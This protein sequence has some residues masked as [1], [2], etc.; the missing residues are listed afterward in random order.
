MTFMGVS[1]HFAGRIIA[2]KRRAEALSRDIAREH[3]V[4][5]FK[6]EDAEA[7]MTEALEGERDSTKE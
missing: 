1:N 7:V 5:K 4:L 3:V 6:D 2:T